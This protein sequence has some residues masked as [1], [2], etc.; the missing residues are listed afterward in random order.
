LLL[1]EHPLGNWRVSILTNN[2]KRSNPGW[3]CTLSLYLL[4][5]YLLKDGTAA[6]N[7]TKTAKYKAKVFI[8]LD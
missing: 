8:F 3:H 4:S 7:A 2:T 1:P 5:F 6:A